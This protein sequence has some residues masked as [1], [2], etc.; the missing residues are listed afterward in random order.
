MIS[1]TPVFSSGPESCVIL[2]KFCTVN[3]KEDLE[4]ID[5]VVSLYKTLDSKYENVHV[6]DPYEFICPDEFCVSYDKI[7]DFLWY[8]DDDH[9]SVEGSE[10]LSRHF[11]DWFKREFKAH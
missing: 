5:P 9:L 3:K 4:R 7:S 8:R 10:S 2:G 1:P 6:Y 11:D